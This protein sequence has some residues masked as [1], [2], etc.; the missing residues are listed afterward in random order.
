MK[1]KPVVTDY[2]SVRHTSSLIDFHFTN[3]LTILTGDSGEGKTLV[4]T[5]LREESAADERLVCLNYLNIRD[6]ILELLGRYTGK[7]IV[8]DNADI[9]LTDE[10]RKYIS[11][12][13]SNQYLIIGRNP[14]NLL[15]TKDNL[16]I[17]KAARKGE[18][19]IFSLEAL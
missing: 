9:L 1:I 2:L 6:N 19:T 14:A 5:I 17:L 4:Y 8:I 13:I 11:T 16:F 10:V 3:N 12:D 7:V 18:E 15:T